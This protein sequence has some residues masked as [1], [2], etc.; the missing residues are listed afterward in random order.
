MKGQVDPSQR[1]QELEDITAEIS[2]AVRARM[3]PVQDTQDLLARVTLNAE[4]V[5]TPQHEFTAI[6]STELR[7]NVTRRRSNERARDSVGST[8]VPIRS[9]VSRRPQ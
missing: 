3:V 9:L 6:P 8:S 1:M 5:R 4:P 2:S 7:R